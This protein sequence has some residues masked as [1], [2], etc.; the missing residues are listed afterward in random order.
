MWIRPLFTII[1]FNS[2]LI[3]QIGKLGLIFDTRPCEI[4]DL[5]VSSRQVARVARTRG[6]RPRGSTRTPVRS[7]TWRVGAGMWRAHRLVGPG[8]SI[9]AVTQMRY[10]LLRFILTFSRSFFRVGLCSHIF[11]PCAGHMAAS[12]TL[13]TRASIQ[14]RRYNGL[15]VH[16]IVNHNTCVKNAFKWSDRGL[17]LHHVASSDGCDSSLFRRIMGGRVEASR[18]SNRRSNVLNLIVDLTTCHRVYDWGATWTQWEGSILIK[19][20]ILSGRVIFIVRRKYH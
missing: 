15:I 5:T 10:A 19:R 1:P 20:A 14:P 18:C 13:D 4:D 2:L 6:R 12:R 8:E 9:G 16:M 17:A 3:P 11:L 7:T